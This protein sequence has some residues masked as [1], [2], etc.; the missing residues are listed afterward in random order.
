MSE[1]D[2]ILVWQDGPIGRLRLNRPRALNAVTHAMINTM[3][4]ALLHW[5][6]DDSI[7]SVMIDAEGDRAFC[8]G[9][10]IRALCELGCKDLARARRFLIEEYQLNAMIA[11]YPKPYI[12]LMDGLT[13]GGGVGVAAHGSHRIVTQHTTLAMPEVAIG[14]HPDIGGT[15]MLAR[16]PGK[17]GMYMGMTGNHVSAPDAIYT[18]FA[19]HH[20]THEK[21]HEFTAAL[22]DGLP[23]DT[24][25][26][27]FAGAPGDSELE[28][29]QSKINDAFGQTSAL[30]CQRRLDELALEGDDWA[31]RTRKAMQKNAPLSMAATFLTLTRLGK[32][33]TVENCIS[34]EF[35]FVSRALEGHDL[36]EGVR[37]ILV[38]KDRNP[39]WQFS[40]LAD[41]PQ[42]LVT[43]YLAPLGSS[44]WT[45]RENTSREV[46]WQKSVL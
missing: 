34:A 29:H 23:L 39:H 15:Y 9:G 18:G 38:D 31:T 14:F 1:T 21:L 22:I 4:D 6:E 19:D 26:A 20:I 33:S 36:Y 24:T 2:H 16:A 12:A 13:M 40:T 43:D 8:A 7:T 35:R 32:N 37:S 30:G 25:I 3:T 27:M 42:Q 10:D 17:T 5:L 11:R 41:V 45:P 28:Q 44:E 46:K